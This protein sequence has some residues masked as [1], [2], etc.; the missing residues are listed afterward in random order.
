MSA[1]DA[2]SIRPAGPEDAAPFC[3]LISRLLLELNPDYAEYY[4]EARLAPVVERLLRDEPGYFG[5]IASDETGQPAGAIALNECAA[6]YAL[7]RFGEITELYVEPAHR[8]ARLGQR[9]LDHA[10]AFA[11]TRGWTVLEVSAPEQ[12]RWRRSLDF[13]LRGGF[14][15]VGPRLYLVIE[16]P[17]GPA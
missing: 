2:Y 11:A 6:A 10:K 5:F 9:M 16:D 13:Y 7:G 17:T 8:S 3:R 12:P 4:G 15:E 1:T 14:A